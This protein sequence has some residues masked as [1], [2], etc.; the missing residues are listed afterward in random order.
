MSQLNSI[1]ALKLQRQQMQEQQ[2]REDN[3]RADA[4]VQAAVQKLLTGQQQLAQQQLGMDKIALET[5]KQQQT[6]E[7]ARQKQ[8]IENKKWEYEQ[9]TT[10]E[11]EAKYNRDVQAA[12]LAEDQI[13]NWR[14]H[15]SQPT[16][17]RQ[18]LMEHNEAKRQGKSVSDYGGK[19]SK[20]VS[21][22]ANKIIQAISRTGKRQGQLRVLAGT[23]NVPEVKEKLKVLQQ[24]TSRVDQLSAEAKKTLDPAEQARI[25]E[26][27][28]QIDAYFQE[29]GLVPVEEIGPGAAV[30][31][32][33]TAP[34]GTAPQQQGG[35]D[36]E[37]V[38]DE[39]KTEEKPFTAAPAPRQT[40]STAQRKQ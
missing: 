29:G 19:L 3:I 4:S 6:M 35:I 21:G 37:G 13:K 14:H 38:A 27:L 1:L 31:Q 40:V 12:A 23:E 36:W 32:Q 5:M 9:P 24:I 15:R 18:V 33:G 16:N 8:R 2:A 11:R 7:I 39:M 30:P 26:Q 10:L 28:R 25:E 22:R 34:K 17:F 20:R